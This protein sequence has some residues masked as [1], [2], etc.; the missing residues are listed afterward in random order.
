MKILLTIVLSYVIGSFS[1][2]YV[3]GKMFKNVDIRYYGSGNAGTTN[4]VRVFGKKIGLMAFVLDVLKG[5]IAI[6]I[7]GKILGYD[8]KLIAGFF[9]V[10]GHNWPILLN[11]KG[12]KGIATSFG[13]LL[14]IHWPTAVISLLFFIVVLV[15]SRYVSLSSMTSATVVPIVVA[16]VKEPF[17]K[18][19]FIVTLILAALAIFRHRANIKRLLNGQEYKVGD[20][21]N[22]G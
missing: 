10:I 1:S 8:G 16:L 21:V 22:R 13:V 12:G 2:A 14:S 6:Y 20:K 4:A 7:G 18:K 17:D 3:L 15:I 19:F 5:M 11:F 9:A